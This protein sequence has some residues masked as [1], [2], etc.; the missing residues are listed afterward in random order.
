M[1]VKLHEAFCLD[2]ALKRT[3]YLDHFL[4]KQLKDEWRAALGGTA[5]VVDLQLG[6][7]VR[8]S[9]GAVALNG[10]RIDWNDI[11]TL[12]AS[13]RVSMEVR[14]KLG[15]DELFG[16]DIG[17][18]DTRLVANRWINFSVGGGNFRIE[19]QDFAG[20]TFFDSGVP[21]DT[22]YH[23]FRIEVHAAD[24]HFAGVHA[25]Y[26]IDD[27]QTDNSPITTNVP[28]DYLQPVIVVFTTEDVDKTIDVDYVAI[29]QDR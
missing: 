26:Y 27:V 22:D 16:L 1:S 20:G 23:T 18:T 7:I 5:V 11:R 2:S 29:R 13:K 4:G 28:L 17:L 3:W 8:L 10:S 24:E 9:T 21:H 12:L 6:G 19:A 25:H 14:A 15:L